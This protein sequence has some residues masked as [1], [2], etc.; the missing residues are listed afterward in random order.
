MEI[1]GT[2]PGL[3]ISRD[4]AERHAGF[5]RTRSCLRTAARPEL[6]SGTV[7]T[8]RLPFGAQERR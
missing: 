2:V 3:W 4:I 7:F 6:S 5:F 1:G 8:F